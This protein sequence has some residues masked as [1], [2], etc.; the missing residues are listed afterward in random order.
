MSK[1]T[2]THLKSAICQNSSHQWGEWHLN[3]LMCTSTRICKRCGE[4]ETEQ[5]EHQWGEWEFV[6]NTCVQRRICTY[7]GS[8]EEKNVEH[9]WVESI[10]KDTIKCKR[11]S[12]V[13]ELT[14][15]KHA[16][17]DWQ[18]TKEYNCGNGQKIRECKQCHT[19]EISQKYHHTLGEWK[20]INESCVN[21]REC[22]VCGYKERKDEHTWEEWVQDDECHRHRSCK[23]CGK[24]EKIEEHKWGEWTYNEQCNCSRVCRQCKTF[25]QNGIKHDYE[26]T[27]ATVTS[28]RRMGSG[29]DWE[30]HYI[31][32]WKCKRCEDMK[33]D[34]RSDWGNS[35]EVY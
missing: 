31:C 16:W 26:L 30:N 19:V 18:N 28:S 13:I 4:E 3:D 7:C 15:P 6:N 17:M 2:L 29:D 21:E 22:Q 14:N 5:T 23:Y 10:C 25:E 34:T 33:T 8:K 20:H 32:E 35:I 9:D 27:K 24:L 12:K 1:F 11:C